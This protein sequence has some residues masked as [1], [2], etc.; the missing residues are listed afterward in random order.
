MIPLA[1]IRNPAHLLVVRVM[2]AHSLKK[3]VMMIGLF[4]T[5]RAGDG[6]D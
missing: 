3:W 4:M 2:A 5:V 1:A 6:R